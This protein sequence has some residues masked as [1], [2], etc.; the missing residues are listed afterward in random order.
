MRKALFAALAVAVMGSMMI[1][2][3]TARRAGP[4]RTYI[5]L[6]DASASAADGRAAVESA[7][8]KVVHENR[9]V[10]VATVKSVARDF[11]LA[12]NDEAALA[13]AAQNVPI[14]TAGPAE[15]EKPEIE[16]LDRGRATATGE[17]IVEDASAAGEAE[18]LAD[19]QWDMKEMDA[20][21]DGSYAS[22]P[23]NPDVLVGVIDTGVD[24]SHPDIAPNFNGELSRN[25]TTDI[26]L[27]DGA[28]KKDPDESCE[29]PPTVDED[30]H[31]THV[32][33][34]IAA[35]I[36][37]LGTAGV[38]PEVTIANL[39]AGQDSGYFFLQPSVDALTFAGD[40]G[41][42][43]V[44]MSYFIDPW[45]YNCA[46]NPA[47]SPEDQ[48]E[49]QT[50]IAATQRAVDYAYERDVALVAA[51]GNQFTDLGNPTVDSI[52]PDFPP[53]EEITRTVD[54]SCL[55][56]P[57]E[58]EHVMSINA[59]GPSLRKSFYS[60]YG[61]EQST[62]AAPGGD[63][64]DFPGTDRFGAI[65]NRILAPY[66]Q[67]V[68]EAN[69]ELRPNGTPNTPFVVRDC[70][71][72]ECAYYQYLQG[73]SM[74]SP[75]AVGVAAL[76]VS[77]FGEGAG[78]ALTLDPEQTEGIMRSTAVN[79]ACPEPRLFSY[80]ASGL[81]PEFDAFCAGGPG[82]NG[83]YGDGVVNALRAVRG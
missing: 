5:V 3:A 55:T 80:A 50:I 77:E 18:P 11:V 4:E 40:H 17:G 48:L 81:G 76:I 27:V 79:R 44:N 21:V 24:A 12:A 15:R 35:P 73:T 10:G 72:D 28:C 82:F 32:A 1:G 39:R 65:D 41:F 25:F 64:L 30:G 37:G 20:T 38:A 22:Q 57:T 26:P 6:Y 54:N 29:D 78:E 52:S 13:G 49:Q 34:T 69:K 47:D 63:S 62:V 43:V 58:T 42:D 16:R 59:I 51:S 53:G 36:N 60:N 66:P 8:G 19:L 9:A 71:G 45:L 83:F 7:G 68:A 33:G 70:I 14:G 75:H 56:V 74:A 46:N 61:V 2:P 67:S 31:G 23:G